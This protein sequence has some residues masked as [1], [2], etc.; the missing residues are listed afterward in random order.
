M[1]SLPAK[2]KRERW[3]P[4]ICWEIVSTEPGFVPGPCVCLDKEDI[5]PS[6]FVVDAFGM[7]IAFNLS[8]AILERYNDCILDYVGNRFMFV[9][10]NMTSFLGS[11]AKN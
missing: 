5:I 4:I 9:D 2:M 11:E 8:E 6:D 10:R 1:D 7:K 3:L